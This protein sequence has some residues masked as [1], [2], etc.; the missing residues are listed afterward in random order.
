[1][2]NR[3]RFSKAISSLNIQIVSAQIIHAMGYAHALCFYYFGLSTSHIF[4][5]NFAVDD[6]PIKQLLR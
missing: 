1:M 6:W 2:K 3:G 4:Q 5:D